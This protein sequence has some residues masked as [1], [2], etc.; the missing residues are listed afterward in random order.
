LHSAQTILFLHRIML[1]FFPHL[2]SDFVFSPILLLTPGI[3]RVLTL[4]IAQL[5]FTSHQTLF[6]PSFEIRLR[7]FPILNPIGSALIFTLLPQWH[8]AQKRTAILF[9]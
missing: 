2:K 8:I 4:H 3:A 7:F 9:F 1:C 5:V 6:F